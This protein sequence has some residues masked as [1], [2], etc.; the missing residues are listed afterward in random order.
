MRTYAP[1]GGIATYRTEIAKDPNAR[2]L[3]VHWA[4]VPEC[5][6]Q[7]GREHKLV[8][9]L[10]GRRVRDIAVAKIGLP[11]QPF[12]YLRDRAKTEIGQVVSP[13]R[14]CFSLS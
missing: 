8:L 10:A 9:F 13:E 2:K 12:H 6:I 11:A 1:R 4:S 7:A 5:Q 14:I 3:P